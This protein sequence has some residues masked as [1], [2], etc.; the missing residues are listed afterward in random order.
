MNHCPWRRAPSG[1]V[2]ALLLAAGCLLPTGSSGLAGPAVVLEQHREI[3]PPEQDEQVRCGG[4][5][6]ISGAL[7]TWGTWDATGGCSG[8]PEEP[9]GG[10]LN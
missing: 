8:K 5:K 9:C 1:V 10:I 3:R 4:I 2:V 6:T 7:G